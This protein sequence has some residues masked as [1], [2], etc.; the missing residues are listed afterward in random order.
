MVAASGEAPADHPGSIPGSTTFGNPGERP[1]VQYSTHGRAG[2]GF[3]AAPSGRS[4]ALRSNRSDSPGRAAP[5]MGTL[6]VVGTAHLDTQ[7]RWTIRETVDR[8]LPSTVR[9]NA[10]CFAEFPSYV[11][12]FDGAFRYALLEEHFPDAFEQ[13]RHWVRAGRWHPAGAFFDAADVNI[14]SPESLVRHV[15]YGNGYLRRAFGHQ[16]SDVFL[17]DCFGFGWALPSV[18]SHCGLRGFSTSKLVKWFPRERLPFELGVWEGPDGRGIL[19]ALLPGG[20]GTTIDGDLSRDPEWRA[21]VEEQGRTTGAHVALRYFGTGDRGGAPDGETLRWLERSIAGDG[22]LEVRSATSEALFRELEGEAVEAMP[23]FSG[24]LLLPTHGTGC[25]TSQAAMKR[26]NRHNEMLAAAAEA[27]AVAAD[28]CGAMAYPRERLKEAWQRFLWHQH[29]DDVTGTSVP[30][31]YRYSWNDELLSLGQLATVLR[32]A[33]GAVGHGLDTAVGGEPIVVYNPLPWARSGRVEVPL[34]GEAARWSHPCAVG[35]DGEP[36]PSQLARGSDGR[37]RL[38]FL[39]H[40]PAV[41]LAVYELLDGGPRRGVAP[42]EGPERELASGRL[43]IRVNERGDLASLRDMRLG[44]EL[45]AAPV[46]LEL[47]A[48]RSR[49][50]PAWEIQYR[51]VVAPP[52]RRVGAP[53]TVEVLERGPVRHL[54]EVRRRAAG[55][56]FVERIA[57]GGAEEDG[58]V[59]IDLTI[60]WRTRGRLLKAAFPVAV[61][62]PVATYDLGWGAI[63]RPPNTPFRYEVPAQQWADL[64]AGSGDLGLAIANDGRV[65]WDRPSPSV[66]RLSLLRSPAVGRRF[67]HQAI[68][69]WGRHR[70]RLA[71]IPHRGDWASGQV[72]RRA[73]EHNQPLR[74]FRVSK[75][76]GALGRTFS[77]LELE[78]PAVALR[79]LKGPEEGSGWILR[80][81]EAAGRPL[82]GASA[83]LVGPIRRVQETDGC[84]RDAGALASEGQR[85]VLDLTPF[86]PRTLRVELAPPAVGVAPPRFLPLPLACDSDVAS[87]NGERV[88]EGLGRR[89]WA[90]PAELLPRV[91]HQAGVE[92]HLA[93]GRG[94]VPNA[95]RCRGQRLPLPPGEEWRVLY[96]VV[97]VGDRDLSARFDLGGRHLTVAVPASRGW[98]GQWRR[99]RRWG[100]PLGRG[101]GPGYV[102]RA[103]L[104]WVGSHHHDRR[105]RDEPYGSCY[106]FR[107]RFELEDRVGEVGLPEAPELRVL[108]ATVATWGA[109]EATPV[110]PL[111][112]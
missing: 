99:R 69:D 49:R 42:V 4:D 98:I 94:G 25:W 73:L 77:L 9:D 59:E 55:S 18:A 70:L 93:P 22:P 87:R 110:E 60:D 107:L 15:L 88:V 106:L 51:D 75:H 8:F 112:D 26:W 79:A 62:E 3:P 102:K 45:L 50:W 71:L 27:A 104:A 14:P 52:R 1:A 85:L 35:P 47:L 56:S 16:A 40:V 61:T 12:N 67:R 63:Q 29:H 28:W 81:Q 54:L 92:L 44:A 23:R 101:V 13:V 24:E 2:R 36:V 64:S 74:A 7:W 96:L 97:G 80:L 105:G 5:R 38:L 11:L 20:Y 109:D 41:G 76:G 19:A 37:P 48:D 89:R 33:V 58:T 32:E 57:I 43:R 53:A 90:L 95:V 17:P 103:I 39:A 46:G 68:Q 83:R 31:A 34:D 100:W 108:A 6:F 86:Q 111:F 78:S 65:G 10:R 84:E 66:V 21:R 72:A 82:E 30:E 91:L